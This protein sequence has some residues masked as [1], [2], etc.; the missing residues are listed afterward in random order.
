VAARN[1]DCRARKR[2]KA[3]GAQQPNNQTKDQARQ[4]GP[5]TELS[6]KD[7]LH[8]GPQLPA[9]KSVIRPLDHLFDPEMAIFRNPVVAATLRCSLRCYRER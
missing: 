2:G 4:R 5:I 7:L 1:H 3:G 9:A 8:R 6:R